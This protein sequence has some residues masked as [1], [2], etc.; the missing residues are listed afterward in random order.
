MSEGYLTRKEQVDR[1]IENMRRFGE[2]LRRSK[3]KT[4]E[5]LIKG[6]FMT[7]DGKLTKRYGG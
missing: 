6:G 7:E 5:F 2:K 3:K 1:E 4:R